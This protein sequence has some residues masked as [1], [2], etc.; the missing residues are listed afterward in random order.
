MSSKSVRRLIKENKKEKK[1]WARKEKRTRGSSVS[2]SSLP[3]VDSSVVSLNGED[4]R[5]VEEKLNSANNQAREMK[6]TTDCNPPLRL[7]DVLESNP[8]DGVKPIQESFHTS[9]DY[10][11]DDEDSIG[12]EDIGL[13]R[14]QPQDVP[15]SGRI[16]DHCHDDAM[17]DPVQFSAAIE[18][19]AAYFDNTSRAEVVNQV[20]HTSQSNDEEAKLE[21]DQKM[22]QQTREATAPSSSAV[23]TQKRKHQRKQ[24]VLLPTDAAQDPSWFAERGLMSRSS[25]KLMKKEMK[26]RLA[27]IID[28]DSLCSDITVPDDYVHDGSAEEGHQFSNC[29]IEEEKKIDDNMSSLTMSQHSGSRVSFRKRVSEID[30]DDDSSLEEGKEQMHV[31]IQVPE[32]FVDDISKLDFDWKTS[33]RTIQRHWAKNGGGLDDDDDESSSDTDS[34]DVDIEEMERM[35]NASARSFE[36]ATTRGSS[37]RSRSILKRKMKRTS[38]VSSTSSKRVSW[39]ASNNQILGGSTKLKADSAHHTASD[40]VLT[41]CLRSNTPLVE[42]EVIKRPSDAVPNAAK[43]SVMPKRAP[44]KDKETPAFSPSLQS[45]VGN[46]SSATT[47]SFGDGAEEGRNRA[48]AEVIQSVLESKSERRKVGLS[49]DEVNVLHK[50]VK[51]LSNTDSESDDS[52]T[53]TSTPLEEPNVLLED[54]PVPVQTVKRNFNRAET[55]QVSNK[56]KTQA[57]MLAKV[58]REMSA[59]LERSRSHRSKQLKSNGKVEIEDNT[60]HLVLDKQPLPKQAEKAAKRPPSTQPSLARKESPQEETAKIT[61]TKASRDTHNIPNDGMIARDVATNKKPTLQDLIGSNKRDD[62]RSIDARSVMCLDPRSIADPEALSSSAQQQRQKSDVLRSQNDVTAHKMEVKQTRQVSKTNIDTH[63]DILTL[64]ISNLSVIMLVNIYGRLREMSMLGHASVKLRDIDVNSHQR[65]S[66]LKEL[67]RL[68]LLKPKDKNKGYLETTLTAGFIVRAAIDEYEMFES[69]SLLENGALSTVKKASMEYDATV[70]T[71]F[72]AWV[73]ES[74]TKNFDGQCFEN[75]SVMRDLVDSSLE[76]VWISDRHPDDVSYCICVNRMTSRVIVVFR[77]VEGVLR[78]VKDSKMMDYKNPLAKESGNTDTEFMQL[79]AAVAKNI[80]TPRLDTKMSIVNEIADRF[81]KIRGELTGR[82][83]CHLTICGHNLG[84]G[85][86]TVTGFYLACNKDLEL[87]SPIQIVTFASPRVGGKEF[88]RSFQHLED[89]GRILYARFTNMND[90]ISLRPFWAL[91]GPS[92]K[93][94]D[95]YK[96]SNCVLTTYFSLFSVLNIFRPKIMTQHVGMHICLDTRSVLGFDLHYRR[97][98]GLPDEL[99]NLIK[100]YFC[101]N[102]KKSSILEYH[103]RLRFAKKQFSSQQKRL[104][105]RKRKELITL[106]EC[107]SL[108]E[109]FTAFD[110]DVKGSTSSLLKLVIVAFFIVI[111]AG[112]LLRIMVSHG[113]T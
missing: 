96:V 88:Q 81:N 97:A 40:S 86:A 21:Y 98:I 4:E 103:R 31:T 51:R 9:H 36:T 8:S 73:A 20:D 100:S 91:S 49:P 6:R 62:A 34:D 47:T 23:I 58:A 111:E 104:S 65:N 112:L 61:A 113:Y 64:G 1:L 69:C 89:T 2:Q 55:L 90:M 15:P 60:A 68:H 78:R 102:S 99:W 48:F 18:A 3:S 10:F 11:N 93:F 14:K 17:Q 46:M 22:K 26:N 13:Q 105:K 74:L 75:G 84:G 85:L 24:S 109:T 67:R 59:S 12:L 42:N 29:V 41:S 71:D 7:S 37:Q 30:G 94:E 52:T 5:H 95:W 77:G 33:S 66:R 106:E 63:E 25:M 107:Y 83:P 82:D 50:M 79:R 57:E 27:D 80:L 108:Q 101:G 72:K 38:S 43:E 16:P 35:C 53:T 70:V 39:N 56:S 28:D 45:G 110:G 54:K 87:A 19:T 92:W 76:V 32:K 44:S